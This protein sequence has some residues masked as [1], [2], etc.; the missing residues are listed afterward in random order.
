MEKKNITIGVLLSGCGNRD[1]SE[2][3]ESVMTLLALAKANVEYRCFAPDM[4]QTFVINHLTGEKMH[5]K[6][7]VLVEA[8]RIARG[9]ITPLNLF[10]AKQCDALILPGG[11][12][13]AL[14]LSSF[15]KDGTASIIHPEVVR[16]VTSMHE[17]KK[18]L[19][20]LCIAPTILAKLIPGVSLTIGT[21]Q[22]TAQTLESMGAKH[23]ETK[24]RTIVVDPMKKVV[25]SPCYMLNATVAD[26][27]H[28]AEQV[29]QAIL[30]LLQKK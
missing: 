29:V 4:E 7:N 1:G 28:E 10:D 22:K 17:L 23:K 12:G 16:A 2:I 5:E 8:A 13:A 9:K 30:E 27:A 21:D 18:P 26:I 24:Q 20:A 25:T 6:R 3:H 15:A 11:Q 14:N 19:G